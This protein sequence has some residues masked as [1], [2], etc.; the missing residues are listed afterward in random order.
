[1][2]LSITGYFSEIDIKFAKSA[3]HADLRQVQLHE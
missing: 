1:M 2:Q 3:Y